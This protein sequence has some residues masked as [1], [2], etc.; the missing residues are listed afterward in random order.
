M[1]TLFARVPIEMIKILSPPRIDGVLDDPVWK[2]AKGYSDFISYYPDYGKLPK[3]KTIVYSA[4]DA[5]NLY[6]AFKCFESDPGKVIGTIRKRDTIG[7]EDLVAIAIDSHNDGQNAYSFAINPRGIQQDG[8]MDSLGDFDFLA[9]FIW[10][11]V[12]VIDAEGYTVEVRIPFKTLRFAN[13]KIVKMRIGFFRKINRYSE[14][15][16]F[17][18]SLPKG[19]SLEYLG[20]CQFE[21]IKHKRVLQVLPSVTYMKRRERNVDQALASFD[22]KNLGFTS[23]IG[24]TSDLTLDLTFNPDFSHIEI[25]EGQVDVNLR[26][27]PLYEEK[28][29]FFLE[30]LEHFHFAVG[31]DFHIEKIVHTR[32]I[33][34]PL[35]GL[36]LSGKIGRYSVINSLFSVDESPKNIASEIPG[37]GEES[38]NN[39]YGI[40]RYKHLLKNDSYVGSIYTGKEL[41]FNNDGEGET[42][43]GF[44]R[45]VGVD[46]RV[47]FRGFMTLEAFFLYSFNKLYNIDLEAVDNTKGPAFGGRFKYEDRKTLVALGYHELSSNFNL[48]VGRLLRKGIRSF[49]LE[50]ERYIYPPSEF[51]KL[52]TLRYSGRLSRDTEYHMNEYAHQFAVAFQLP[53]ST[54]LSLRYDLAT[55]V[56][57]GG[58]FNKDTFFTFGSSRPSKH[59]QLTFIYSSGGSPFYH[60][61][62]PFQ[63]HLETL[64]ISINF[65]PNKKFSTQFNWTNHIFHG[66]EVSTEDYN[67]SIYRNKTIF[68]V[69]KYL[70]LR[71]IVEYDTGDKKI[72]GDA[73]VEFTYIPGTV[74]HLGYGSTFS[75]EY[76]LEGRTLHYHHFEETRSSFFFKA[77]YLFRF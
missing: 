56:F 74:I 59:L 17:P 13:T 14:Q 2:K 29:P 67:I 39:Y 50:A 18:E 62:P 57:A 77:S 54:Q 47:R 73:L 19:S 28:R 26:V 36:K 60:S 63:G 52:V 23:K 35:W 70:S 16:S 64:F 25:D 6:F 20:F 4:Y 68:Q 65:Q 76:D 12:G 48:E 38:G 72:L 31:D 55:E 34:E 71:G 33:V 9:D 10:E 44:H 53:L 22:E 51:L 40:F 32:N 7:S 43:S 75:K 58:V 11:S 1:S 37:P 30:G 24:V 69:N 3:E 49:S 15:Y 61:L 21:G 66:D 27:E 41:R 8:I 46:S 5:D 45:V 42:I